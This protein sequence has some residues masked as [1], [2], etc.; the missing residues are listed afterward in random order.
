MFK[1]GE[2]G[3][4]LQRDK[5][6]VAIAPHIPCGVVSSDQLRTIANVADKYG[7]SAIKLTSAARIVIVG[8]K[9]EDLDNIWSDLDMKPGHAIGLCVRSLK[10]C[11][12]TTF[13]KLAKKDSLSVGMKLDELYHGMNLPNKTKIA[14]SGCNN[15]CAENC[16]KDVSLLGKQ[17]GWTL[18]AGG[19][20]GSKPRLADIIIENISDEEA[21]RLIDKI[22]V[23][24]KNNSKKLERIGKMIDRIGLDKFKS[25][26][27][28]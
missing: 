26:I 23:F 22:I 14:V 1:D 7:S 18:M 15:Q 19:K 10:V 25:N 20:G 8:I 24:Y 6:T 27:I 28:C 3:A 16:I 9:Q 5:K 2:K 11:P 12:G 4:I 13:C 21:F 17:N